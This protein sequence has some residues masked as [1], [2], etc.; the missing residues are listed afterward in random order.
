MVTHP[1]RQFL[2]S[3]LAAAVFAAPIVGEAGGL[4][5]I[6]PRRIGPHPAGAIRRVALHNIHTNEA[7]DAVY[8]ER[9]AYVPEALGDV[10]HV[11]RDFRTGDVHPIDNRL[12]NLLDSLSGKVETWRP[13]SVISG[14]RSPKTNAM[15]H[16]T[17]PGVANNSLHMKGMAIDIRVEGVDLGHLHKAAMTLNGG[18]VGYY[19]SSDFIHVDVGAVRHWG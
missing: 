15:L 12:L 7:I 17:T 10:S 6:T 16:E 14:Y 18:G 4:R 5:R 19:P 8:W 9:G 2:K 3:G 11:L 13:F 1:R